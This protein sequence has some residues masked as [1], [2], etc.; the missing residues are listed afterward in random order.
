MIE[1]KHVSIMIPL[2]TLWFCGPIRSPCITIKPQSMCA[3]PLLNRFAPVKPAVE[4]FN[5]LDPLGAAALHPQAIRSIPNRWL[6]IKIVCEAT[7]IHIVLPQTGRPCEICCT[8]L[9]IF[10]QMRAENDWWI[11][12]KRKSSSGAAALLVYLFQH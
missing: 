7:Q 1:N 12:M 2:N 11:C 3:G 6:F 10:F 4:D 5:D 8:Y 9:Y